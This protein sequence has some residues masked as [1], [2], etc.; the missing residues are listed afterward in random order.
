MITYEIHALKSLMNQL[1]AGDSFDHFLLEEAAIRTA[2]SYSID[3]HIN[4]EFYPKEERGE[5]C[6]P[7]EF[8]PWSQVK[9]LCFQLIKGKYTPLSFKFVLQLKPEQAAALLAGENCTLDASFI[10]ALV[11]TIKYDGVKATITTGISYHTFV[12]NKEPDAIWD[13]AVARFLSKREISYE[14]L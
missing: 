13:K 11:L 8:Q 10:K 12:M 14:P 3:G 6:I 2:L 5:D 4:T 1:L 9:G 7:Y